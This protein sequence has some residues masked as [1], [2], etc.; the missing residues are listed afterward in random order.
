M[1]PGVIVGINYR[2]ENLHQEV[3]RLT[4]GRGSWPDAD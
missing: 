2:Q 3:M 1:L 4:N